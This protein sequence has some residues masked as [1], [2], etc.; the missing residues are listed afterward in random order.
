MNPEQSSISIINKNNGQLTGESSNALPIR[1][2]ADFSWVKIFF[3]GFF[4]AFLIMFIF[5]ST[6]KRQVVVVEVAGRTADYTEY[7][8]Q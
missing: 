1:I 7:K 6:I 2:M 3:A 4:T 8:I 5:V